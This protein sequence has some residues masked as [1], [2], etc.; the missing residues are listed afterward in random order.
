VSSGVRVHLLVIVM[1]IRHAAGRGLRV[2][3]AHD[4]TARPRGQVCRVG[5]YTVGGMVFFDLL[6][7]TCAAAGERRAGRRASG[8][9]PGTGFAR[10]RGARNVAGCYL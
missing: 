4:T 10:G 3:A 6:E 5:R 9:G 7:T 1:R 2:I 8:G